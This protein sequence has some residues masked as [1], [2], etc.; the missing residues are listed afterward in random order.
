[1]GH[2]RPDGLIGWRVECEGML[3]LIA[4]ALVLTGCGGGTNDSTT[5]TIPCRRNARFGVSRISAL[6]PRIGHFKN[7]L[8]IGAVEMQVELT[9]VRLG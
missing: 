1:M 6:G 7:A 8:G 3:W 9:A 2:Q 5:P 4:S